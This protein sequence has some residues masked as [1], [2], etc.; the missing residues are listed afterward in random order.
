MWMCSF[1]RHFTLYTVTFPFSELLNTEVFKI[2]IV[3]HSTFYFLRGD[4][5]II[6][7]T[8]SFSLSGLLCI[9]C[10]KIKI[11]RRSCFPVGTMSPYWMTLK[12]AYEFLGTFFR[13]QKNE[14]YK[15]PAWTAKMQEYPWFADK[16][17]PCRGTCSAP[18]I[19]QLVRQGLT[20][21]FFFVNCRCRRFQH[22]SRNT[23]GRVT[24]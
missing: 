5:K 1:C 12:C 15:C 8:R 13:C 11:L 21:K 4:N 9:H 19:S 2:K 17:R 18:K 23:A 22:T 16:P 14:L 6:G 7:I 3:L 10:R 20:F 24:I